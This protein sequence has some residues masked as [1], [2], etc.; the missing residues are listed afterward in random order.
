MKRKGEIT[1]VRGKGYRVPST[2]GNR[3]GE[4]VVGRGSSV[5]K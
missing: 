5:E 3:R 1:G 2:T 4:E